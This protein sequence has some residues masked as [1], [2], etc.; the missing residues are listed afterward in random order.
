MVF[1][2]GRTNI[3]KLVFCKG[4]QFTYPIVRGIFFFAMQIELQLA[5]GRPT[6]LA[7]IGRLDVGTILSLTFFREECLV[8]PTELVS[9]R[10]SC[11]FWTGLPHPWLGS[12]YIPRLQV[13]LA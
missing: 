11:L 2:L 13:P 7:P 5:L 9:T 4:Q 8:A 6:V 3:D 10:G 1:L 12:V